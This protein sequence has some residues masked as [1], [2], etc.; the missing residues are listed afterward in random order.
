MH[1]ISLDDLPAADL[2]GLLRGDLPAE[3]PRGGLVALLDFLPLGADAL[4][5]RAAAARLSAEVVEG[6]R[7]F[8]RFPEG[9]DLLE[10][11]R[12]VGAHAGAVV[13]RHP[14]RGAVRAAAA[15]SR[16]PV[17][18]AGDGTGEDPL[19]ALGDL[20]V[21][22]AELGG[23]SGRSVALCGDLRRNR[24]VHSLAGGLVACG[25]RVLFVPAR[26]AEPDE[27]FLHRLGVARGCH[28]VR[29][30]E[31][32]M[33]SLFDMV[34]SW[35]LTPDVDHQL[36][37]LPDLDA[38]SDLDR[39]R[40][41]HQVRRIDAMWL[42]AARDDEGEPVEDPAPRALPWR[43]EDGREFTT[44]SRPRDTP[45]D[46]V[47]RADSAVKPLAAVL[48]RALRG[49]A[50]P[51]VMPEGVYCAAEGLRCAEA[52]CVACREPARVMPAFA[53]VRTDPVLLSC[54]Y[55]LARRKA[56]YIGSRVEKRY[57]RLT[58][59]QV[60][61]ILPRN[62]VFFGSGREAEAAGFVSSRIE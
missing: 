17:L 45:V 21:L 13:L 48:A 40:V 30:A 27:S 35:L 22:S 28:P 19:F 36:P 14:L 59:S 50:P 10:A 43:G 11:A 38:S 9:V 47:R 61:K 46:W 24:R 26:G 52:S 6:A 31:Q 12:A 1:L 23:L 34:D 41:R 15:V 39:R 37:L 44:P 54:V 56:Q 32:S 18:S 53:L 60:R 8:P 7:L 3:T 20:A 57:H 5:L 58:S 25:A 2:R 16:A 33:D 4:A 49:P 42:A 51:P 55:C 62:A 29:F